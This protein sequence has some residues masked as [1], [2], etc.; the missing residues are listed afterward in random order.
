MGVILVVE[1][2]VVAGLI[3]FNALI[4]FAAMSKTRKIQLEIYEDK[5][6]DFYLSLLNWK[7]TDK[8][9]IEV[10]KTIVNA[11]HFDKDTLEGIDI[12]PAQKERIKERLQAIQEFL[13]KS[14]KDSEDYYKVSKATLEEFN[15]SAFAKELNALLYG[16]EARKLL[17]GTE[18]SM[19]VKTS[20]ASL[21]KF[22]TSLMN[23]LATT[24]ELPLFENKSGAYSV[25]TD[26]NGYMV[27]EFG[28][29]EYTIE[30]DFFIQTGKGIK[31][32]HPVNDILLLSDEEDIETIFLTI[33]DT[34]I[35]LHEKEDEI[36]MAIYENVAEKQGYLYISNATIGQT[37]S[38]PKDLFKNG[39]LT[40]PEMYHTIEQAFTTMLKLP[41][42]T[43]EQIE[44]RNRDIITIYG[45]LEK[46]YPD[47]TQHTACTITGYIAASAGLLDSEGIYL[48]SDRKAPYRKYLR[49]TVYN[50]IQ[51]HQA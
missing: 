22:I 30:A 4:I 28:K 35:R 38:I 24:I 36:E 19:E 17:T 8:A 39:E 20:I 1:P 3:Y 42:N 40:E 44:S 7:T 16:L 31:C 41:A 45:V 9:D 10:L 11:I 2:R 5:L 13:F 18:E 12:S 49:D 43:P 23:A 47:I 6:T 48:V 33:G 46:H 15:N 50:I 21:T 37:I 25:R 14:K 32:L 51:K 29:G 27:Y 26:K 34:A